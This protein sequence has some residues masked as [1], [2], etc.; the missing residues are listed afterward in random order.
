MKTFSFSETKKVIGTPI[1]FY[2]LM[3][4]TRCVG[5]GSGPEAM[6]DHGQRKLEDI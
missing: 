6:A 5:D 3:I 2:G 1:I 4:K